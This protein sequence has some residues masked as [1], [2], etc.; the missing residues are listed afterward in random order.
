MNIN[1]LQPFTPLAVQKN[2]HG[3]SFDQH[4]V[5]KPETCFIATFKSQQGR[6]KSHGKIC[7]FRKNKCNRFRHKQS[8]FF[9]RNLRVFFVA[10]NLVVIIDDAC[11]V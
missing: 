4:I 1:C 5:P 3:I 9:I 7:R 11:Q 6:I 10:L 8:N 2:N